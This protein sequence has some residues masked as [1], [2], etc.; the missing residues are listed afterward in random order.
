MIKKQKLKH[1]KT[2]LN[3]I[4]LLSKQKKITQNKK[5]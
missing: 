4:N 2:I 5:T 1:K 3:I